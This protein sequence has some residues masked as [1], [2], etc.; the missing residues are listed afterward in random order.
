MIRPMVQPRLTRP[1]R[2]A[3]GY[4]REGRRRALAAAGRWGVA[5]SVPLPR[6]GPCPPFAVI[7][8]YR[9]RNSRLLER[10][11]E[12]CQ[13]VGAHIA[14][15]A[16]DEYSAPLRPFTV[17]SGAGS[18]FDLLNET[19]SLAQISDDRYLVV[20]DDDV[21]L[22]AGIPRVVALAEAAGL[23][24]AMPAHL[25]YSHFSHRLTRRRRWAAVR[26]TTYVETGPLLVIAPAWRNRIT[27]F[28]PDSGMG[29]GT[30]LGWMA[31]RGEGCRLGIV[32][33]APVLHL[34]PPGRDYDQ[35]AEMARLDGALRAAGVPEDGPM[36]AQVDSLLRV[37]GTWP[38]LRPVPAW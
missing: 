9:A 1:Y 15:W 29:W 37:L 28:P 10:L 32:D 19:L 12:P 23:G 5:P 13:K 3:R 7:G 36:R 2:V 26:L 11:L 38:L 34:V 31:L 4:S 33:A 6:V 16:L 35:S 8:V 21:V 25:P 30:D 18:R 14:L 17:G 20:V 22:P 27:P 24:L